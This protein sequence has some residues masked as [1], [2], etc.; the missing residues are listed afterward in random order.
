ME[1]V[2][3]LHFSHETGFLFFQVGELIKKIQDS[4]VET[5]EELGWMDEESKEKARE[6]VK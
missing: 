6:K 2:H 5:L 3:V 4:Y 1:C